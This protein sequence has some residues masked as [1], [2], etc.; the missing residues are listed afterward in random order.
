MTVEQSK[1]RSVGLRIDL[2]QDRA[3]D[4]H[5]GTPALK[6]HVRSEQPLMLGGVPR[7]LMAE[8]DQT[9]HPFLPGYEPAEPQPGGDQKLGRLARDDTASR[10]AV[11]KY[12]LARTI[13]E[14]EIRHLVDEALVPARSV[15][16]VPQ[17]RA[18]QRRV[19]MNAERVHWCRHR[20]MHAEVI[21]PSKLLSTLPEGR[22]GGA[23]NVSVGIIQGGC[24]DPGFLEEACRGVAQRLE[25]GSDRLKRSDGEMGPRLG[26]PLPRDECSYA[27]RDWESRDTSGRMHLRPRVLGPLLRPQQDDGQRERHASE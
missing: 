7:G 8:A 14:A 2:V 26:H 16:R 13:L 11:T 5:R 17:G 18:R 24:G 21:I 15:I 22:H 9:G 6:L 27:L 23:A 4:V 1:E 25:A 20:D 10:Q 12:S 3:R 19:G